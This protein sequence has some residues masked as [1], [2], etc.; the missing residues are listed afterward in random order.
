VI[1][2][3]KNVKVKSSSISTNTVLQVS[4][5]SSDVGSDF[6]NIIPYPSKHNVAKN[7]DFIYYWNIKGFFGTKKSMSFINDMKARFLIT[8]KDEVKEVK[9]Y[10]T[11]EKWF[12]KLGH[13]QHLKSIAVNKINETNRFDNARDMIFW[14]I[15]LYA[16]DVIKERGSV[17]YDTL[18]E[19]GITNFDPHIGVDKACKDFST[20]RA[21][22]K[23]IFNYYDNKNFRLDKYER[24]CTDEEYKMT[25]AQ[26]MKRVKERQAEETRKKIE[27]FMSGMFID[28][29]KKPNGAW[30]KSKLAEALNISRQTLANYI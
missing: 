25:R 13:F 15:K 28:E 3:K 23:S 16:E 21:K 4:F 20:L 6:G 11:E 2:H 1:L 30:N 19:F 24:K 12:N 17:D 8:Y 14:C 5:R 7:G 10:N 29:Y 26:N 22:C 18:L 9:H 27:H